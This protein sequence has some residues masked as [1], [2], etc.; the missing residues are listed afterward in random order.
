MSATCGGVLVRAVSSLVLSQ[1]HN[2]MQNKEISEKYTAS[3]FAGVF[4]A[5]YFRPTKLSEDFHQV[6]I[7]FQFL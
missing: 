6:R 7:I 4:L 1:Q 2:S 3:F 5:E